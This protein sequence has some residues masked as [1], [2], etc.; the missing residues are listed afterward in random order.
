MIRILI[1]IIYFALALGIGEVG[2][3]MVL[4]MAG[5]AANAHKHDQISYSKWNRMLWR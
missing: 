5:R 2:V 4:E 3:N 1:C